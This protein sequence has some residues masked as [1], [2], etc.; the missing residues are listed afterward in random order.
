MFWL[1]SSHAKEGVVP[2]TVNLQAA[3][4]D[5]VA[6]G[7]ALFPVPAEDPNDPLQWPRWKKTTILAICSLYSFLSNTALLGP[8]VYI[9]IFAKSF[10]ISPTKA[11]GLV[12]YP[13]ILYGVGTLITVPAYLKFGRRPVMLISI[14]IYLAGLVGCSQANSYSG[15][16]VA[17][18][19]HTFGSGVCEALPVQLVN[20]I[21]FRKLTWCCS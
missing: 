17:R 15:L 18:L 13:N 21:F 6:Y 7:Q 9:S 2:G 19:I 3:E 14:L 4:G 12:S 1:L 10:D 20:D 5:D 8:S 16:M 11:S